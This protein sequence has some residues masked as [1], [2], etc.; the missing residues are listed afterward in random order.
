[1]PL[2]E[3]A[4]LSKPLQMLEPARAA[5]T[6]GRLVWPTAL[7]AVFALQMGRHAES[8]SAADCPTAGYR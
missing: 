5:C 1:M 6:D 7:A 8:I 3:P 2:R 4:G